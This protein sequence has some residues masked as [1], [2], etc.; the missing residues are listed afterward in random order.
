MSKVYVSFLGTGTGNGYNRVRYVIS[1]TE[2][3]HTQFAQRA[4]IQ[5]HDPASFDRIHIFMTAMSRDKHWDM[6]RDELIGIGVKPEALLP[7]D[8]ITT[9]MTPEDQWSWF[10]DMLKAIDNDDEVIIDFTHGFRSFQIIFSSAI[11]FLQKARKFRLLHAYYGYVNLDSERGEIVDMASF[12]RINDWADAVARLT[13]TADASKLAL[14]AQEEED[15]SFAAL[16]DPKLVEALQ[17]LT[18][19]IKNIDVNR[20]GTIADT[21]LEI[22]GKKMA[23][24]SGANLRLLEMVQDKF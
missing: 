16:N 23:V 1:G 5:H 22:I 20:V 21:A 13:E 10:E 18:D 3:D 8:T 6:L 9:S 19:I 4:I 7:H 24:S 14:L 12:Y 11:G 15:G 2:S 17:S